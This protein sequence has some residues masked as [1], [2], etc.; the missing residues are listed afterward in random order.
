MQSLMEK[1]Q[2]VLLQRR[3]F[4]TA[5]ELPRPR[6]ELPASFNG[7]HTELSH[8]AEKIEALSMGSLPNR[9]GTTQDLPLSPLKTL[10]ESWPSDIY[11]F[12]SLGLSVEERYTFA[13]PQPT[14][15]IPSSP[16]VAE[17][18]KFNF[19]HGALSSGLVEETSYMAWF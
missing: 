19:D 17:N 14:P 16:R 1:S 2:R 8:L 11:H 4:E 13:A 10:Q 6:P 9:I 5:L 7:V 15:F 12:S 18:E 3:G